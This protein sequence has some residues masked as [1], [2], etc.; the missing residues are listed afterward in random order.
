MASTRLPDKLMLAAA[1]KPI[2]QHVIERA[3][4]AAAQSDGRISQV[5]VAYD[6]ERLRQIALACGVRAIATGTHHACGT[7][8]I[9]EAVEAL[10]DDSIDFVVNV[11]GDEPEIAPE[12]I[13]T[14][15]EALL[16]DERAPMATL[17]T[18]MPKGSEGMKANPNAV[19]VVIDKSGKAIYFSRAPV[20][21]DRARSEEGEALWHHHLGI[22]AYRRDFL[23]EFAALPPSA[24]EVREGLEQLRAIEHG[25]AIRVG[26]VPAAWAA[27]GIDTAEDFAAFARRAG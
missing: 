11:Q 3:Q 15:V 20:P 7:T 6:D 2:L 19:K 27:K 17:A 9:A 12:A 4:T 24:L 13:L 5:V 18:A 16:A 22:Y 25:H 26:I 21:Y 1:G 8:R 14:V 10:G 23:T